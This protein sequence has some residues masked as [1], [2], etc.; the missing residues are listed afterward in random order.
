MWENGDLQ[1][2]QLSEE[3]R[4]LA[5]FF[6][7]QECGN[8]LSPLPP[9][10]A[11]CFWWW[12]LGSVFFPPWEHPSQICPLPGLVLGHHPPAMLRESISPAVLTPRRDKHP[13]VLPQ[14]G[15]VS[16]EAG[17]QQPPSHRALSPACSQRPRERVPLPRNAKMLSTKQPRAGKAGPA[18]EN[19]D[20]EK[21][22]TEPRGGLSGGSCGAAEHHLLTASIAG[23]ELPCQEVFVLTPGRAQEEISLWRPHQCECFCE[24]G[25]SGVP[26]ELPVLGIPCFPPCSPCMPL[27]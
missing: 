11:E 27:L 12:S 4:A 6:G 5:S 21:V 18:T 23:G 13:P 26:C 17:G 8:C 22:S 10:P 9:C 3:V 2:L 25:G 19:V 24:G 1:D 20:P 14:A 16:L 15:R 7:V